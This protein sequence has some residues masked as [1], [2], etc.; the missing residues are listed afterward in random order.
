MQNKNNIDF[1]KVTDNPKVVELIKMR[2]EIE[3]KIR[4]LDVMAL[5]KYE[6]ESLDNA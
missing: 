2:E 3:K 4:K 6:I 5:L 1:S